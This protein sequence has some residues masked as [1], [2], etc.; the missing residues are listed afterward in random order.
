L[1]RLQGLTLD[2][3]LRWLLGLT[4]NGRASLLRRRLNRC[5]PLNVYATRL[6]RLCA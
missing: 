2:C 5:W 4:L 3:A 1:L 6:R